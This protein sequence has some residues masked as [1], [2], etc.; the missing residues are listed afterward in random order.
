ML[1]S[2][3]RKNAKSWLIKLI[4]VII[5]VVFV[6]YFGYSFTGQETAKVATVNGENITAQEYQKAYD[7][8]RTS[9]QEQ[10][11]DMWNESLIKALDLENRTLEQLIQQKVLE[12]EAKKLGLEVT[13]KEVQDAIISYDAFKSG[14]VFD[15]AKYNAL[16]SNNRTTAENFEKSVEQ[17]LLKQKVAQFLTSFL[18]ISDQEVKDLYTYANEKVKIS[19]VTFSPSDYLSSVTVDKASMNK[20]FEAH[21]ENFRMP[22]K[23]KISYVSVGPEEFIGQVKVDEDEIKTYYED[24]PSN[25]QEEKQVKAG[26]ILFKL[27]ENATAETEKTVKAKAEKVLEKARASE[28]FAKLAKEY[29]ED[30]STKSN[31]G[32]LGYFKKG[33]MVSAF[34]TAAFSLPKGGISNL[35]KTSFGYH[36]IKVEDIKEAKTLNLQEAHDQIASM[37]ATSK[38]KELADEKI[39]SFVDKM[40][41][42]VD[43]I[44]YAGQK[45]FSATTSDYFSEERPLQFLEGQTKV[46]NTIFSLQPKEMSDI[47]EV[48]NR[49]FVVQVV[50]KKAAYLPNIIEVSTE[51]EETYKAY[52][53]QQKAKAAAE[54]YLARLKG[55]SD[56]SAL[57]QER[58]MTPVTTDFF[59]RQDLPKGFE[60]IQGFDNAVFKLNQ[61]KRYP[62]NAFESETGAYVVKW[63]DKKGID[64]VK[65]NAEKDKYISNLQSMKQQYAYN[66]WMQRLMK[67]SVIDRTNSAKNK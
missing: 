27:S 18:V 24:N 32:D 55:G 3:M 25:F 1:L 62:D 64:D 8:Y 2:L 57:A 33:Q 54:E 46:L 11:K 42:D 47:V 14:G 59:T 13:Q 34:E 15:N 63:E 48:N 37:L 56:W 29:S 36:I 30:V 40:A 45:G 58:K 67:N 52:L 39:L 41:S 35:V 26:H 28:D 60:S 9:F 6:F 22:A 23:I 65:F 20:F 12:Q 38:A 5:A 50:D 53:A 51:V 10:Y 43:L 66:A 7:E 61:N 49:F 21:K 31:G 4:M 16:L 17:N 19:Y 44:Q